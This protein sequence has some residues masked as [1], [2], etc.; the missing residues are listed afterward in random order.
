[1]VEK[2]KTRQAIESLYHGICTI[3]NR[4]SFFDE[5][6]KQT[7]FREVEIVKDEPCRLSFSALTTVLQRQG[8]SETTQ[9]VKLFIAPEINIA[10]GAKITVTQNDK[11]SYYSQ[12][13]EVALYS[14]HQEIKLELWQKWA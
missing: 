14:S 12:S 7:K 3:T 11:T 5:V 8:A 13:G 9:A 10:P 2:S 1:M 4:E 6:T